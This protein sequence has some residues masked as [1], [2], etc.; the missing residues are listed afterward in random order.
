MEQTENT[1]RSKTAKESIIYSTKD[2]DEP[3][4]GSNYRCQNT[5]EKEKE[6]GIIYVEGIENDTDF[7]P[8][9]PKS[10]IEPVRKYES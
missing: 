10:P 2:L 5:K 1:D 9:V 4:F 8:L 3:M 7:V 6:D